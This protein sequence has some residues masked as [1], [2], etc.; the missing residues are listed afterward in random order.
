MKPALS[1][2]STSDL[3]LR[4]LDA[5]LKVSLVLAGLLIATAAMQWIWKVSAARRACLLLFGAI[6]IPVIAISSFTTQD[7]KAV[8]EVEAVPSS[9]KIPSTPV[10]PPVELKRHP[11]GAA[12]DFA[13]AKLNMPSSKVAPLPEVAPTPVG[14]ANPVRWDWWIMAI[15]IA[16]IGLVCTRLAIAITYLN[17]RARKMSASVHAGLLVGALTDLCVEAGVRRIPQLLL[18]HQGNVMPMTWGAWRHRILLPAEADTWD[19]GRL[20]LVL[21]HELAHIQRRDCLATWT[22][23]LLLAPTWF[24]PLAWVVARQADDLRERAA[25]DLVSGR[26]HDPERYARELV[27]FSKCH[28]GLAGSLAMARPRRLEA[29]I[30][31]LFAPQ[32]GRRAASRAF[33]ASVAVSLTIALSPMWFFAACQTTEQAPAAAQTLQAQAKPTHPSA[34]LTTTPDPVF[35]KGDK[36]VDL[37]LIEVTYESGV[38]TVYM[39]DAREQLL[40]GTLA[41]PAVIPAK[42]MAMMPNMKGADLISTPAFPSGKRHHVKITRAYV[43]PSEPTAEDAG[44]EMVTRDVG[45]MGDALVTQR[46]DGKLSVDLDF[47]L[48]EFSGIENDS[49][50]IGRPVFETQKMDT[51]PVIVENGGGVSFGV[52]R[53]DVQSVEDKVPILGDI[54]LVGRLFRSEAENHF[55]R[56]L[57]FRVSVAD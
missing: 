44:Q 55:R 10:E 9:A 38:D 23:R 46:G 18:A 27:A 8:W 47:Q 40:A 39:I 25:D 22:M 48:V 32:L 41:E 34:K 1:E 57:V 51:P 29:R 56:L 16:G 33:R 24:L 13:A 11:I 2:L 54:P 31:A 49:A 12:I 21:R 20:L 37:Q 50:G 52:L 28:Q 7:R 42:T 4:L 43:Y 26:F 35:H 3:M 19:D 45:L 14:A 5:S 30:R 15:W 6:S 36:K 53:E 17:W